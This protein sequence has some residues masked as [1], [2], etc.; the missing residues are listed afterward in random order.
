MPDARSESGRRKPI[1]F[2]EQNDRVAGFYRDKPDLC[3]TNQRP[4]I[5]AFGELYLL[6]GEMQGD[7]IGGLR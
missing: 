7:L 5:A 1:R 3:Q 2:F 4:R 6:L